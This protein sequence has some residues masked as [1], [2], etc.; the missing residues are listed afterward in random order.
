MTVRQRIQHKDE[1]SSERF[2][3]RDPDWGEIAASVKDFL[4][5]EGKLR[6]NSVAL[7]FEVNKIEL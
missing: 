1:Y 5:A 3:I 7:D 4:D 6:E 2:T